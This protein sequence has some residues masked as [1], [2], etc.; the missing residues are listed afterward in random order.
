MEK[1]IFAVVGALA[2]FGL[3]IYWVYA[4]FS[5]GNNPMGWAGLVALI[6]GVFILYLG[7]KD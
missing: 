1:W 7:L 4:Y 6:V 2:C 5:R 3:A